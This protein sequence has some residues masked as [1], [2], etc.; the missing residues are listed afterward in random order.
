MALLSLR[1]PP[2]KELTFEQLIEQNVDGL[3][4]A[5][6]R[7]TRA[8]QRAEALV[9]DT[10]VR[11]LRFRDS[12]KM[13]T[14]FKAW[15]YTILTNTFIHKYR[16]QQREREI[17]NGSHRADVEQRL[18]SDAARDAA[19][20][21]ENTY[22]RNM[23]SDDVLHALDSLAEDYR[24]VIVLCDLEGLSYKEIAE[25]IDRP[26]GTVMS[27]LYRGRRILEGKLRAGAAEQ[28]LIKGESSEE[29]EQAKG[30]D[31][32]DINRFRRRRRA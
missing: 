23:L 1:K 30:S 28:G 4:R 13:G 24:T 27:R 6:M 2:V 15:I 17:L 3:Y 18:H 7:Y 29:A 10:V 19:T 8:P 22:L 14:N 25:V 11:A 12:F 9:H 16:R 20:S 26:V 31:V 21:P 32:L 5:A